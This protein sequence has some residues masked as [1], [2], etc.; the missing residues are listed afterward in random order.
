MALPK[1]KSPIFELKLP[2]SGKAVK[3]RPFLVKEQKLLLMALES[4]DSEEMFRAIKQIINNCAVDTIDVDE[5]P[6]FDLEYFFLRLRAKSIGEIVELKL[7]HLDEKNSKGAECSHATPFEL[8]LLEV[9]VQKVEGH[10]NKI[11][12]D[13]QTKIGVAFNYP[14]VSLANKLQKLGAQNQIDSVV[15]VIVE[16]IDYIFDADNVYSSKETST[17]ELIDFV[18]DLSQEQF[19]KLAEFFNKMPKLKH[20]IKWKCQGC[21]TTDSIEIEG[22][23]N[24]FG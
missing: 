20:T 21:G 7:K 18:N 2:S 4:E 17:D 6:M 12:L 10:S 5:L 14:T 24:F 23:A 22:M 8:N 13:E 16:S 3:Y 15:S 9:E 19:G 11:I 1:I